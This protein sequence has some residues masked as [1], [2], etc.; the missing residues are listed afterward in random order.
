MVFFLL[1]CILGE[2]IRKSSDECQENDECCNLG[3]K[4]RYKTTISENWRQ[5]LSCK[6]SRNIGQY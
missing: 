3:K 6:Q 2:I 1:L 4:R 5:N